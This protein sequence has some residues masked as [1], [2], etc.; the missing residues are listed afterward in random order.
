MNQSHDI[1]EESEGQPDSSLL[2]I[3]DPLSEEHVSNTMARFSPQGQEP[4]FG[5]SPTYSYQTSTN[6]HHHN[7]QHNNHHD[8]TGNHVMMFYATRPDSAQSHSNVH[9][10]ENEEQVVDSKRSS[11]I[12]GEDSFV[13]SSGSSPARRVRDADFS[14]YLKQARRSI[15]R[16][17]SS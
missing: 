15:G 17:M 6:V 12:E 16:H 11:Y 1:D 10:I 2:G 8:T 7:T 3:H 4:E 13:A 9:S 5:M 14:K